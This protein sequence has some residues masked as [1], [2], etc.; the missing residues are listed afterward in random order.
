ML[1]AGVGLCWLSVPLVAHHSFA[2]EYDNTKPVGGTGVV[3]K[4]EWT[5][6][7]MRIYV[8]APDENGV[9]T[10]WNLELGSPNS[11]LRRGWTRSDLKAGD[12][13]TFKGYGGK[14]VLTRAVADAITLA[15]GRAF[16]GASGAPDK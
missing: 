13:I 12:K 14:K 4:V 2:A 6:P 1:V 10:T 11:V 16:T 3:T 5:N 15:D 7:H 8:D 9:M